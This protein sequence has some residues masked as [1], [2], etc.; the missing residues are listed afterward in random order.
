MSFWLLYLK[1]M[2][3]TMRNKSVL[4][5][6]NI[7]QLTC[8]NGGL[9]CNCHCRDGWSPGIAESLL[10][11]HTVCLRVHSETARGACTDWQCGGRAINLHD[12]WNVYGMSNCTRPFND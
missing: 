3:K 11:C 7:E 6:L 5:L 12:N 10:E 2:E 4:E 9:A 1:F 8:V